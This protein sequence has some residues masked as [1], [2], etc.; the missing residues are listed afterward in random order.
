MSPRHRHRSASTISRGRRI[1]R[2][3]PSSPLQLQGANSP[4][5]ARGKDRGTEGRRDGGT[6][7]HRNGGTE[8]RFFSAVSQ[9]LRPS[10][11]PSLRP[12]VSPSLCLF[13]HVGARLYDVNLIADCDPFY[14]LVASAERGFDLQRAAGK[15]PPDCYSHNTAFTVTPY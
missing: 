10:V 4:R 7:R 14:V 15:S 1:H 11:P 12:S 9:S 6:E 5:A 2:Q 13:F 3:P 8:R